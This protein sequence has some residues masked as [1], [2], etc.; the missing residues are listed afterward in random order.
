MKQYM[1]QGYY[2]KVGEEEYH[3]K[4]WN[5]LPHSFEDALKSARNL[6]KY[7]IE[8]EKYPSGPVLVRLVEIEK[9]V[10]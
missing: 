4:D 3:W 2:R 8:P 10:V 9:K 7:S 1:V 6:M 5:S